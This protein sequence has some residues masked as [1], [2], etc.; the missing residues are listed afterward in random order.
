[1]PLNAG[2]LRHRVTLRTRPQ[3]QPTDGYGAAVE[4]GS[5]AAEVWAQV[6]TL[7]ARELVL[8]QQQAAEASVAVT[9]RWR[10]DVDRFHQVVHGL[11]VLNIVGV[12]DPDGRKEQLDL[13]CTE[14][15]R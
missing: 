13:T 12:V 7:S 1:M 5:L 9:I 3:P 4:S 8:A 10:P 2:D 11:R 6:R 15:V 14:P